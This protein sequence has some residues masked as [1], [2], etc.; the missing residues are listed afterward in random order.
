[1]ETRNDAES[2]DMV[3][4][5]RVRDLEG[6]LIRVLDLEIAPDIVLQ[7][8]VWHPGFVAA[9]DERD[10]EAEEICSF[11]NETFILDNPRSYAG[12]VEGE[13]LNN[14]D[15]LVARWSAE[16][17]P[18]DTPRPPLSDWEEMVSAGPHVP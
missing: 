7:A 2:L 13:L 14:E 3:M 11:L 18:A 1:M 8:D 4:R 15:E 12:Q 10:L 17:L 6:H 5:V 9:P 16:L